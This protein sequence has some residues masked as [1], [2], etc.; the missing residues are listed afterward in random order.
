MDAQVGVLVQNVLSLQEGICLR[1]MKVLLYSMISDA[2]GWSFSSCND[3][4]KAVNLQI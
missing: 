2:E 1:K 4:G 3:R